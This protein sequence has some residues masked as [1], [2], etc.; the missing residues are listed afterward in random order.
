MA[1]TKYYTF[2]HKPG[3][4]VPQEAES[5]SKFKS[6]IAKSEEQFLYEITR[7]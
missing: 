5:Y 3:G 6:D 2:K 4:D 1:K 7:F